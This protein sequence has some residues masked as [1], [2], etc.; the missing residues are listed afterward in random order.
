MVA[1]RRKKIAVFGER[2]RK[3]RREA[4]V[5]LRAEIRGNAGAFGGRFTS[6]L[7]LGAPDR[8]QR[9]SRWFD[10]Y[11][12]GSGHFTIWN[13]T[14][15]TARLAF[16]D[17]VSERAFIS[18]YEALSGSQRVEEFATDF[19]VTDQARDGN[20]RI[21]SVLAR[22]PI[23]YPQ[24]DGRTFS[25]QVEQ[26]EA[27]IILEEPPEIR[28]SFKVDRGF[29]YGAGLDIIVDAECIDRS[30]IEST[31]D[32]FFAVGET[33]WIASEAVPREELAPPVKLRDL[34]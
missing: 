19:Q 7:V 17:A 29:A 14:I 22:D 23:R 15:R 16:S 30:V 27:K 1:G 32:R 10:F 31:M 6:P 13:A 26:L 5:R 8:P 9:E 2:S 21:D 28:E 33:D 3:Y 11:F 34:R 24:F 20:T 25:E 18:T 4:V 12:V